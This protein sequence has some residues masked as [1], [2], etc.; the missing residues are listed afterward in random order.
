MVYL[1][2]S[3]L[4]DL[5]CFK[6]SDVRRGR[7]HYATSAM[8]PSSCDPRQQPQE[9]EEPSTSLLPRRWPLSA[10][11][12]TPPP[13]EPRAARR[14]ET[15]R[16]GSHRRASR[17][18]VTGYDHPAA[19]FASIFRLGQEPVSSLKSGSLGTHAHEWERRSLRTSSVDCW[20]GLPARR[21]ERRYETLPPAL[22]VP[23]DSELSRT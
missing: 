6:V 13:T 7:R 16:L 2:L 19:F 17:G 4:R 22:H 10:R 15:T 3:I 11:G 12:S 20:L 23:G 8:P 1:S 5:V 21:N 18:E 9:T 14:A